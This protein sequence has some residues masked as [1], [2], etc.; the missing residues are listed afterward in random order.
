MY[1]EDLKMLEMNGK[2]EW[3]TSQIP[4]WSKIVTPLRVYEW[5]ANLSS[6]PDKEFYSYI[7]SGIANGFRIGFDHRR[8]CGAVKANMLSAQRNPS[9]VEDYLRVEIEEG[10]VPGPIAQPGS[11]H[12][13]H[14]GVIPKR[15]QVGKWRLIVDL[16]HPE[17]ASINDGIPPERCSLRYP[18]VDDAVW[19]I[20]KLGRG[21]L[22]AKWDIKNAYRMVPVHP[23]DRKLLGM[24]GM[25]KHL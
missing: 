24:Y 6:H 4:R 8:H 12:I 16:S 2:G 3:V 22:L 18:S 21:T 13:N 9:V 25:V 19:I 7:I 15:H 11:L 20:N 17:G 10:R 14:F 5:R 23:A 1:M